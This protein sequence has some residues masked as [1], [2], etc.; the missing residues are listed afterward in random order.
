MDGQIVSKCRTVIDFMVFAILEKVEKSMPKW[1]PKVMKNHPKWHPGALIVDLFFVFIDFGRS[2]KKH[3]FSMRFR[4][5]QKT[6]KIEPWSAKGSKKSPR[7]EPGQRPV[8]RG[9][10]GTRV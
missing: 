8:A 1:L 6:T 2:R 5:D 4:G 3:D 9:G 10:H 7:A